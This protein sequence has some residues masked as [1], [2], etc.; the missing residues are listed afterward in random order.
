MA[1]ITPLCLATSVSMAYLLSLLHAS[2]SLTLSL[3]Q[4]SKRPWKEARD[5]RHKGGKPTSWEKKMEMKAQTKAYR[6][7]KEAA[8]SE[9]KAKCKDVADKRKAAASRKEENRKKSEVVQVIKNPA[10]LKKMMKNKK[11]KNKLVTR[12]TN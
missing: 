4:V 6:E 12:D 3:S 2:V 1:S 10:T 8:I 7:H 9:Y 5:K 11:M